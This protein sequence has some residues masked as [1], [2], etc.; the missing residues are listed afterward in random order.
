M[1][2]IAQAGEHRFDAL[3]DDEEVDPLDADERDVEPDAGTTQQGR[4][5]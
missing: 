4:E 5:Q 1:L 2:K 3:E